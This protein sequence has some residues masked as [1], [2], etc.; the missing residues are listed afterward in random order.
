MTTKLITAQQIQLSK[1]IRNTASSQL[2]Y[3]DWPR[4]IFFLLY[5]S[6]TLLVF[7]FFFSRVCVCLVLLFACFYQNTKEKQM[8][9]L[10]CTFFK[11]TKHKIKANCIQ[12]RK[13][14]MVTMT[15]NN[16]KICKKEIEVYNP[17][18]PQ[19]YKNDSL[20]IS[21]WASSTT[22]NDFLIQT[23]RENTHKS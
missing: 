1:W 9:P 21:P 17:N 20:F 3:L 19:K 4:T 14:K 23:E 12:Q 6:V 7:V 2:K 11:L 5:D 13:K 10:C 22:Q 16:Q 8:T 18:P 15:K